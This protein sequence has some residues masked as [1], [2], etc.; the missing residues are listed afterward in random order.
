MPST[1]GIRTDTEVNTYSEIHFKM[2]NKLKRSYLWCVFFQYVLE[3]RGN[4]PPTATRNKDLLNINDSETTESSF[5]L[6]RARDSAEDNILLTNQPR[7]VFSQS[8]SRKRVD[9][10]C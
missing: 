8:E 6:S 1:R 10:W 4:L 5:Y 2:R 9:S 3:A 7:A